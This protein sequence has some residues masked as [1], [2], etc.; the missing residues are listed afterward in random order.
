[1]MRNNF[2]QHTLYEVIRM[3]PDATQEYRFE[4]VPMAY[5][6]DDEAEIDEILTKAQNEEQQEVLKEEPK[7][8]PSY[9]FV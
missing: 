5:N 9:N 1:M 2:V 3:Y 6:L 4:Y 7:G 8:E